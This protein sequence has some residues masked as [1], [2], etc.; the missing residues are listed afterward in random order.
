MSR[1][2]ISTKIH[3]YITAKFPKEIYD[4]KRNIPSLLV[5]SSPLKQSL[6]TSF[7]KNSIFKRFYSFIYR[8][9]REGERE[10][11]INVWLPL[12]CPLV[13]TRP[14]TQAHA[15]TGNGTGDPL[16][17]RQALNPLSHTSQGYLLCI[18][19]LREEFHF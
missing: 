5:S 8:G 14:A 17:G 15:L 9:G 11:N 1:K 12:S 4:P 13:G 6:S 7:Y 2:K 16:V 18:L 19:I 10:R 3:S